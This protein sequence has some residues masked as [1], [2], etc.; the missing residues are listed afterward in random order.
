MDSVGGTFI[1]TSSAESAA[2][3]GLRLKNRRK[4]DAFLSQPPGSDAAVTT[5]GDFCCDRS[6]RQC[7]TTEPALIGETDIAAVSHNEVIQDVNAQERS[8]GY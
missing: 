1:M 6:C 5:V 8:G 3:V 4:C 2:A 7:R